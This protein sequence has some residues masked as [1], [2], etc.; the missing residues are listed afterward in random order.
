MATKSH[1]VGLTSKVQISVHGLKSKISAV[2]SADRTLTTPSLQLRVYI[3][4]FLKMLPFYFLV[5]S[6]V[7]ST[8]IHNSEVVCRIW[9]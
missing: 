4:T 2:A 6:L 5:L 3:I 9:R 7:D 8:T 1:G